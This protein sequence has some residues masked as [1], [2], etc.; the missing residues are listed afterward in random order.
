LIGLRSILMVLVILVLVAGCSKNNIGS[1]FPPYKKGNPANEGF[2]KNDDGTFQLFALEAGAVFSNSAPELVELHPPDNTG[3]VDVNTLIVLRFSST[4]NPKENF[5]ND[6]IKIRERN[7]TEN[8]EG[9]FSFAPGSAK[10]VVVFEPAE[11]LRERADFEV[12]LTGSLQDAL[13]TA[14]DPGEG[15]TERIFEFSTG[16]TDAEVAFNIIEALTVPPDNATGVSD[17]ASVLVFFTEAVNTTSSTTGLKK[18]DEGKNDNLRIRDQDNNDILGERSFHYGDRLLVYEPD[19]PLP[20]NKR[21]DVTIADRVENESGDETVGTDYEISFTIIDFLRVTD[22][23]FP[24]NPPLLT[25][26]STL[27]EGRIDMAADQDE[28]KVDVTLDGQGT[29]NSLTVLVWNGNN[30]GII[31]VFTGSIKKGVNSVTV[32]LIPEESK[33]DDPFSDASTL[34]VGAYTTNSGGDR[35]PV[36]PGDGL[37]LII[38]DREAPSLLSLGPPNATPAS[39]EPGEPNLALLTELADLGLHGK[40]DEDLSAVVV[41]FEIAGAPQT[42]AEA[43]PFFAVEYPADS[44]QISQEVTVGEDHLFLTGTLDLDTS[45]IFPGSGFNGFLNS[46]ADPPVTITEIVLTDLV[47]NTTTLTNPDDATIDFRG[48]FLTLNQEVDE[49][50]ILCC[51]SVTLRPVA[52]VDVIFDNQD[53][54]YQEAVTTDENG[55]ASFT[56]FP[57]GFLWD[58]NRI[59]VTAVKDGYAVLSQVWAYEFPTPNRTLNL[60]LTPEDASV[61]NTAVEVTLQN[62]TESDL[63]EVLFGGTEVVPTSESPLVSVGENPSIANATVRNNKLQI[64]QAL[65]V[66]IEPVDAYQWAWLDAIVPATAT[67]QDKN[68]QTAEF[69]AEPAQPDPDESQNLRVD[70]AFGNGASREARLTANLPG[71]TGTLPIGVDRS[72][73]LKNGQY[74]YTVPLPPTLLT[75]EAFPLDSDDALILP[76]ET[77]NFEPPYELVLEPELGRADNTND[78]TTTIFEERCYFEAEEADTGNDPDMVRKRLPYVQNDLDVPRTI[79]LPATLGVPTQNGSDLEWDNVLEDP[80][81]GIDAGVYVLSYEN[82]DGSRQWQVFVDSVVAGNNPV[83]SFL[84]PDLTV[85]ESLPGALGGNDFDDFDASGDY[86]FRVEAYHIDG[87]DLTATFFSDIARKWETY[88]RSEKIQVTR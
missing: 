84:F 30:K 61:T 72:P 1:I 16:R 58:G 64:L 34:I 15:N 18:A 29:A 9:T 56:P 22:I 37:A 38:K 42:P 17:G 73:K 40:A 51:D 74:R 46:D 79:T 63:P 69:L 25:R 68:E 62:D 8:V 78:P 31:S 28:F 88:W 32:D 21:I 39:Q 65:G 35:S 12:A 75:N 13:G 10:T 3:G 6:G 36:G 23:S 50:E 81:N 60:L 33:G 5:L 26:S 67:A 55:E 80:G 54:G 48:F 77:E 27:Y 82:E 86:P 59:V 20:P 83:V 70:P 52:D 87:F 41:T 57:L 47:G 24:D 14:Y 19:N 71:F 45:S 66:D 43:I 76:L 44:G 4:M 11:P 85:Y 49:L 7:A 53:A 2:N